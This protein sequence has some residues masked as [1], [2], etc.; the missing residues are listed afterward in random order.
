[1]R[2]AQLLIKIGT[3]GRRAATG[4]LMVKMIRIRAPSARV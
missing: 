3:G 4:A 2:R 1:V